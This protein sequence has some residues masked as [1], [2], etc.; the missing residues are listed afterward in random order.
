MGQE[1]QSPISHEEA[2]ANT[3]GV[4]PSQDR[5]RPACEVGEVAS[6]AEKGRLGP[7]ENLWKNLNV[8]TG[9]RTAIDTHS[10]ALLDR[11]FFVL[12]LEHNWS[13]AER[14]WACKRSD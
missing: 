5:S 8:A 11:F 7:K 3:F 6:A 9:S 4:I 12:F 13:V 2:E 1:Q 10:R 14:H